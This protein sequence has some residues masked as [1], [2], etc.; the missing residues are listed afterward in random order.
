M[1]M[2]YF[3]TRTA[4]DPKIPLIVLTDRGSASASEIVT[5]AMQELDRGVVIGQRTFGKGLGAANLQ[6]VV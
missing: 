1:N 2:E 6:S 5:G 3:A 4:I